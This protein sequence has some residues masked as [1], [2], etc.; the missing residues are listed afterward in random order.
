MGNRIKDPVQMGTADPDMVRDAGDGQFRVRIVETDE[1]DRFVIIVRVPRD[2]VFLI[3]LDQKREELVQ[4]AQERALLRRPVQAEGSDV[5]ELADQE[6]RFRVMD[7]RRLLVEPAEMEHRRRV[8]AVKPHPVIRPG[9]DGVRSV[10]DILKRPDQESVP[11][12]DRP[13]GGTV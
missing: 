6:I 8:R 3:V 12:P 9:R 5:V 1:L 4:V 11:R 13:C 7:D 10:G 2:D